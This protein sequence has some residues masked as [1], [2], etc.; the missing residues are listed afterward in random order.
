[1]G[2][3]QIRRAEQGGIRADEIPDRTDRY[4]ESG[5]PPTF[6]EAELAG[7]EPPAPPPAGD[8]DRTRSRWRRGR[9]SS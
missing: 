3:A 4:G 5:L 8:T 9:S 6:T 7:M 2:A 1:M